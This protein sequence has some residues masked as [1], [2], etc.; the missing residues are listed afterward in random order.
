MGLVKPTEQSGDKKVDDNKDVRVSAVKG[1]K[2]TTT[3]I[4]AIFTGGKLL[5][6]SSKV[7]LSEGR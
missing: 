7:T 4:S 2:I 3:T 6:A 1:R 5:T